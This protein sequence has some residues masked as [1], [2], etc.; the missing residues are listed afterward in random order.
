[1][2]YHEPYFHFAVFAANQHLVE[3]VLEA[4]A[5]LALLLLPA[6]PRFVARL[7][8]VADLS[9]ELMSRCARS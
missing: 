5:G 4:T 6:V 8:G 9:Q 7:T 3:G 2:K 1:M